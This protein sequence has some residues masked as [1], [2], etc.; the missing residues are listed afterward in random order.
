MTV[1]PGPFVRRMDP[2][3]GSQLGKLL[4][5]HALG[6]VD[7]DGAAGPQRNAAHEKNF[8]DVIKLCVMGNRI[9]EV[10]A[11]GPVDVGGPRVAMI[12]QSLHLAQLP[13]FRH[14][15][16][17]AQAGSGG[18]PDHRLLGEILHAAAAVARPLIH[19]RI[20]SVIDG[21]E[22]EIVHPVRQFAVGA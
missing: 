12:H 21:R 22:R 7:D 2:N 8:L 4:L 14:A 3:G 5:E 20:V 13:T 9:A 16:W 15:F 10:G 1:C 11:D 6:I 18:Q 17:E 19:G